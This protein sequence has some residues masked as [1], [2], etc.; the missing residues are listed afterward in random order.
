MP[1]KLRSY[2]VRIWLRRHDG[3][4]IR[5]EWTEQFEGRSAQHAATVAAKAMAE[6][7]KDTICYIQAKSEPK[8]AGGCPGYADSS[9]QRAIRADYYA[10]AMEQNG[11]LELP[12]DKEDSFGADVLSEMCAQ[13]LATV[14]RSS[15]GVKVFSMADK[16]T[17]D[18]VKA[19]LTTMGYSW[20]GTQIGR[21]GNISV[22]FE[23]R[24]EPPRMASS[25]YYEAETD[26]LCFRRYLFWMKEIKRGWRREWKFEPDEES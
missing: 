14:E 2:D 22:C 15:N 4:F 3:V 18:A 12:R 8:R 20:S 21:D 6:R 13:G 5:T 16:P 1:T 24:P 11:H 9:T 17:L 23:R 10:E 7:F 25:S 26:D 19:E